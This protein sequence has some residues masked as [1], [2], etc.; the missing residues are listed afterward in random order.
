MISETIGRLEAVRKLAAK[1]DP[2][3]PARSAAILDNLSEAARGAAAH[4][5]S[6]GELSDEDRARLGRVQAGCEDELFKARSSAAPAGWGEVAFP[7]V[8]AIVYRV[9][10]PR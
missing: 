5:R 7:L 8:L 3:S 10:D 4:L 1:D 2:D 9:L 6:P